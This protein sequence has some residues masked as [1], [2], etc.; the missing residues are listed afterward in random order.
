MVLAVGHNRRFLPAMRK[1]K[2]M[3]DDGT[4]GKIINIEGNMSGHVG[5][6]YKSGMWRVDRQ[7]SPAGGLAG[8]GIHVIDTMI[9][10][11]GPI[12]EVQA[13]SYRLVHEIEFDDTTNMLFR[14]ASGATG[15]LVAMTAT[16]PTFRIQVF[17]DRGAAELRG[18]T[19]LEFVP[20]SGEKV[21]REY[22]PFSTERAQL[23][24]FADAIEGRTPF[25][26]S[27]DDVIAGIAVFE[28]VPKSAEEHARLHL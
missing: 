8:S 25:P 11:I 13:Q 19:V 9:H 1:L 5:D 17:G 2:S 20:V 21:I 28:A 4:L 24:A 26:V 3:I 27:T 12:A 10:L 7:E 23:E 6:R 18:E 16:A 22:A 14:F 15:Y